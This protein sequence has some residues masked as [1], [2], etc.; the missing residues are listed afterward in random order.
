MRP[1][2]L[3]F[4]ALALIAASLFCLNEARAG[5]V[6]AVGVQS[7]YGQVNCSKNGKGYR[8]EMC[9]TPLA[10]RQAA[11]ASKKFNVQIGILGDAPI[12]WNA[13]RMWALYE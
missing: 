1:N 3:V 11:S 10:F 9:V 2:A 12:H 8:I 7:A 5:S 13:A 6:K 4:S